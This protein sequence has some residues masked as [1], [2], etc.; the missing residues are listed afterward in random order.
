MQT[1]SSVELSKL[2]GKLR[3]FIL[4]SSSNMLILMCSRVGYIVGN[5]GTIYSIALLC[6][7]YFILC[8][9]ILSIC[10]IATN[11]AVQ[12]SWQDM[13]PLQ[14]YVLSNLCLLLEGQEQLLLL[15]LLP[16]DCEC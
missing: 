11:G 7:A 3:D 15:L 13:N 14:H 12:V 5:A 1:P 8:V 9:T 10:A 2:N 16:K 6:V 4:F